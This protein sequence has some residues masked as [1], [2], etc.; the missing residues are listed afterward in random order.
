MLAKL[1]MLINRKLTFHQA[2]LLQGVMMEHID[3]NYANFLH[4]SSMRPYSQYVLPKSESES[5][6]IIQTLNKSAYENII[7]KLSAIDAFTLTHSGEQICNIKEKSTEILPKSELTERFYNA[8]AP[9]SFNIRFITPAAFRQR[10][11]YVIIPDVRL[12]CQSLMLKFSAAYSDIDMMDDDALETIANETFITR[13]NIRSLPFPA[14]GQNIPGFVGSV[15]F[16]SGGSETLRRYLRFLLDFGEFS[17]VGVKTAMGM[18][19]ITVK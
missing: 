2:S 4:Q 16:R 17:G 15:A 8:P 7:Q 10:K 1:R 5:W 19:A 12:I 14:E 9:N 13:H 6:W 18:G 11:R 3:T